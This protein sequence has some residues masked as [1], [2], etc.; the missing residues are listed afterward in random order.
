GAGRPLVFV[1]G[2][3]A[4]SRLWRKVIALL[5]PRFRCVAPDLPLGSH[6]LPM[7][8]DAELTPP[9]PSRAL[10][11]TSSPRAGSTRDGLPLPAL[12]TPHL[13]DPTIAAFSTRSPARATSAPSLQD[14]SPII[15]SR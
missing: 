3:L 10:S 6:R 11:R 14:P 9:G 4:N 8:S 5:E 12:S 15:F 1:H 7:N 13:T 2:L